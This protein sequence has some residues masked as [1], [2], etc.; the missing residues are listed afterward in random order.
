MISRT[1]RRSPR[2]CRSARASRSGL[3]GQA[4]WKKSETA[5]A[6]GSWARAAARSVTETTPRSRPVGSTTGAPE[7]WC[8]TR[9]SA[10]AGRVQS[11]AAARTRG[12]ITSA[13]VIGLM[14]SSFQVRPGV[15]CSRAMIPL[16]APPLSP[17][18]HPHRI[19]AA[20]PTSERTIL[21]TGALGQIGSELVPALRARYGAQRVI[22]TDIRMPPRGTA[23]LGPFD[24]VD[25]TNQRHIQE[26]VRRHDVETIFHLA[27]LLS[28]VAEDRPQV[29]WDINMGGVYRVLEV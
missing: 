10:S 24:F 2:A 15:G 7:I 28:A 29:A 1:V 9:K 23:D 5:A 13:A 3:S 14:G 22:A 21:V 11:A 27:A 6:R 17:A 18:R 25:T 12:F 26:A 8:S 4:L 20:M 19:G 16:M